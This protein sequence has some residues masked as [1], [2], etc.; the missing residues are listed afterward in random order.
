MTELTADKVELRALVSAADSS[1][2]WDLQCHVREQLLAWLRSR[3]RG[4][5]PVRRVES[6]GGNGRP[7]EAGTT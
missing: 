2:L 7:D 5:L 6:V 1:A 3:G 4:H